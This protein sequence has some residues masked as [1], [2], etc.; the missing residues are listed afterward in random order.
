[1]FFMFEY[2]NVKFDEQYFENEPFVISK[3]SKYNNFEDYIKCNYHNYTCISYLLLYSVLYKKE[4][5]EVIYIPLY[6]FYIMS[7][8]PFLVDLAPRL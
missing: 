7:V 1:M 6:S 3:D 2:K 5:S 8:Q 4:M